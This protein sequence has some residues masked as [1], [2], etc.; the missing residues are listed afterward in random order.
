MHGSANEL[1]ARAGGSNPS[2]RQ[3][4][5]V[6]RR[7]RQTIPTL[8]EYTLYEVAGS[9][10]SVT[11]ATLRMQ[12]KF[13]NEC[14]QAVSSTYWKTVY[15]RNNKGKTKAGR[16]ARFPQIQC[17]FEA[18][19]HYGFLV[20]PSGFIRKISNASQHVP[21]KMGFPCTPEVFVDSQSEFGVTQQRSLRTVWCALGDL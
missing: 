10:C 4:C 6:R 18:P 3:P 16:Y 11:V 9:S 15:L 12:A 5:S 1:A 14:S 20:H 17:H 19:T 21:V 2:R 8:Y 13:M 7:P